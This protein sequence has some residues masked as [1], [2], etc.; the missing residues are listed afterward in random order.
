MTCLKFSI[1]ALLCA[2]VI[3]CGSGCEKKSPV[4][5][6]AQNSSNAMKKAGNSV[7]DTA[8][9]T[10]DAVKDTA[11]KA[12]DASKEGVQKASVWATNAANKTA[13]F[14]TNAAAKAK[15]GAKKVESAATNIVNDIKQKVQ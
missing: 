10:K 4:A 9:K 12:V 5:Q 2:L 1:A 8:S 7:K 13:T 14:A 6:F 15:E 11:Q 3:F